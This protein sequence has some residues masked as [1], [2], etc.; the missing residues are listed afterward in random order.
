MIF[1][2]KKD[3]FTLIEI[4]VSLVLAAIIIL[5]FS[6]AIVNGIRSEARIDK[7]LE[8][9]RI[10]NSIAEKLRDIR[11]N[12]DNNWVN[13]QGGFEG[14]QVNFQ[15]TGETIDNNTDDIFIKHEQLNNGIHLFEIIWETRNYNIE[16]LLAGE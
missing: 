7:R 14:Y 15:E 6:S 4:M 8:A 11:E 5:A 3:G 9:I 2:N 12:E 13:I 16:F 1:L 10:S